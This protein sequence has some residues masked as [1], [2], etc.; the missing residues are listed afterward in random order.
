MERYSIEKEVGSGT[1]GIVYLAT[2]NSTGEKVALKQIRRLQSSHGIDTS[3]I[4]EIS[5]LSELNHPNIIRLRDTFT[6]NQT[7]ITLVYEYMESDLS[8]LLRR[9][10][11][12]FT[13]PIIKA[14]MQMILRALDCCH[15]H[16]IL[17]RDLTPQNLLL[18]HDFNL[19][20]SDFGLARYYGSPDQHLSPQACTLWYRPPELL[21]GGTYSNWRLD[22]WS[23]G[24]IFGELLQKAPMFAGRT[25]LEQLAK[26]FQVLGTPSEK[27]WP[28]VTSL[29]AYVAFK[30]Q[31]AIPFTTLFP[32][33]SSDTL[34]LLSSL[35]KLNPAERISAE[36]A[37]KHPFFTKDP[38][39]AS[40]IQLQTELGDSSSILLQEPEEKPY[41]EQKLKPIPKIP[42]FSLSSKLEAVIKLDVEI[43]HLSEQSK[44]EEADRAN[45][46]LEMLKLKLH[47]KEEEELKKQHR[48]EVE[49]ASEAYRQEVEHFTTEWDDA[50][51][52]FEEDA[53][54]RITDLKNRHQQKYAALEKEMQEKEFPAPKLTQECQNIRDTEKQ[55]AKLKKFKEAQRA[56]IAADAMEQEEVEKARKEEQKRRSQRLEQERKELA[57]EMDNLVRQVD[58][59]RKSQI[60]KRAE[61]AAQLEQRYRI[62]IGD[63][64]KK[65]KQEFNDFQK[66]QSK[67][68]T[69]ESTQRISNVRTPIKNSQISSSVQATPDKL[70]HPP[71]TQITPEQPKPSPKKKK[72]PQKQS[73]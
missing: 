39:P 35:L 30:P 37:L 14:L 61:S 33:S 25:D 10:D 20:L 13:V 71:T 38:Q 2:D 24:C 40:L 68:R 44:Y 72:T 53:A 7:D 46:R 70:Y 6:T 52:T 69:R 63:V 54:K 48:E 4:R 28:G 58:R 34:N 21:F 73:E 51:N 32:S 1:Y 50:M 19:K 11:V 55:L 23:A 17:H 3:V 41:V 31:P 45:K 27:N 62:M 57:I 59:E 22:M 15:K 5:T 64:N 65:N 18:S 42:T 36:D 60:I 43:E 47:V 26:I 8:K 16:W 56:K 29:P 67:T 9:H 49:K 12:V 66:K